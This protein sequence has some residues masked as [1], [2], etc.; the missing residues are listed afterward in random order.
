V[1]DG[2]GFLLLAM[3]TA[4]VRGGATKLIVAVVG[5]AALVAVLP[6][7]GQVA[8]DRPLRRS[9]HGG[10]DVGAGIGICVVFTFVV[11]AIAQALGV[12]AALGAFLAGII[13]GRS[14]FVARRVL[15]GIEWMSDAV[16]AP[17]YFA[18]AGVSADVSLLRHGSTA[19]WFVI[20]LVVAFAAK[21]VGVF[22]SARLAR[23]PRREATALGLSL[24]GRGALQVILATAGITAGILSPD[25]FT[26]VILLSLVSSVTVPPALRHALHGWA[27]TEDEQE[28][29][30]HERE[31]TTNVIVRG[32]RL[33]L[34]TRGSANSAAAARLLDLAWPDSSEVTMLVLPEANP[35]GVA[36][37]R[38]TLDTRAVHEEVAE[39]RDIV[40]AILA[41]ANLGYGVIGVGASDSSAQGGPFPPFIEE[42]L[43]RSPIPLVIV[44]RGQRAMTNR[45]GHAPIRPRHVLVPVTGN[46]ASR[47]GQEVAQMVS[48]N[49][50]AE[51][52]L[53]H[54]LTRPGGEPTSDDDTPHARR[55]AT[56]VLTEAR[57]QATAKRLDPDV[58]VR[59]AAFS[60][61]EIEREAERT[62]CDVI[63]LGTTVRRV[64]DRPFL[65]HTVEHLLETVGDPTVVVV[66]LPDAQHLA[67][68]QHVYR[69]LG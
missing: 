21:F 58:V 14:R 11:A 65:G 28:R 18:T 61:H 47:A 27:G 4:L 30:A 56:A 25:A 12:D 64:A 13:I 6:T 45:D 67:A 24:N 66:V 2:V 52:T 29:L 69:D 50:G 37:V 9:R 22:A 3:A 15:D 39:E 36:N 53:L 40:T 23:L 68:D 19:V 44:R 54:V 26:V 10:P 5:L 20:V 42:L 38:R 16:F 31:M 1:N 8:L 32:Q 55:A 17:L 59:D 46:A 48:R 33:L 7:A 49:S 60:P 34:P 57:Q 51:L 62:E 35:A 63:V 43:K 41:E